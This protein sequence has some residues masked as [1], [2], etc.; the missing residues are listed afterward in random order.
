MQKVEGSNP[1]S[2]FLI[3]EPDPADSSA[4]SSAGKG[5]TRNLRA[6]SIAVEHLRCL[7]SSAR[8]QIL[9]GKIF[10]ACQD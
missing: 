1:F 8:L 7:K 5:S 3:A 9:P 2:R 6:T 10:P 4:G